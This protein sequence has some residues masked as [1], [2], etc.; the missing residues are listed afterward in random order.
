MSDVSLGDNVIFSVTASGDTPTYQWYMIDNDGNEM[1][2]SGAM[3]A[4]YTISSVAEEDEG[5]YLCEVSNQAD[6]VNSSVAALE[7]CK[8][9]RGGGE[10]ERER[11]REKE[12]ERVCVYIMHVLVSHTQLNFSIM[13]TVTSHVVC[14][15]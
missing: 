1:M 15:D 10:R 7:L 3:A 8:L 9:E 5:M 6:A 12:K 13:G 14:P 4:T 2:I 11:E